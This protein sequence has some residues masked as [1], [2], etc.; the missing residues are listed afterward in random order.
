MRDV[1]VT[2]EKY[3]GLNE[4]RDRSLLRIFLG[5][6]PKTTPWCAAFVNA[7]LKEEGIKGTGSNLA[8]SFLRWGVPVEGTPELGDIIVFTRGDSSWQGHVGFVSGV[9]PND[10][11][12]ITVLGGNQSDKVCNVRY[13]TEHCLGIRREDV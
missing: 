13:N 6:D 9:D 2:A 8:R 12:R 3:L 4:T 1:L 7:V 10:D 11:T 5:I